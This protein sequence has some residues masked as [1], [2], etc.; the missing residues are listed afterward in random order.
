ME[1]SWSALITKWLYKKPLI[2]RTGY[3]ISRL[4]N[5]LKRFS[6][7][8]RKIYEIIERLS[9]SV[10]DH[11]IVSSKHNKFYIIDKYK[12]KSNKISIIHNFI[13]IESFKILYAFNKR[14]DSIIF[15]GRL[16]EVKN[17][18]RL[19]DAV[20]D[21]R[22]QLTVYGQGPLREQLENYASEKNAN[23]S[24]KGIVSN[25]EL[26]GI[27]NKYKYYILPSLYEGMP[28]TLLEAM[29]CGCV[30]IGTD[31]QGINE[32]IKD[33]FNG[34]LASEPTSESI[35]AT[36]RKASVGDNGIIVNNG[37]KTIKKN[38]SLKSCVEKEKVLFENIEAMRLIE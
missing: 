32:V 5:Q 6:R 4:E 14:K 2:I 34:Y 1:G 12:I 16:S 15:V 37:I 38:F 11:A 7:I 24:F 28:K 22:M 9:Y 8:R 13:D 27:L 19:I 29:A 10:C 20:A 17:L 3:T 21:A 30:C 33:G 23:I 18:F 35:A 31:V 25:N 26:P 36:I